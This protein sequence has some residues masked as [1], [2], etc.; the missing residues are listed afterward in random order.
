MKKYVAIVTEEICASCGGS[1]LVED[2]NGM[3]LLCLPC[4]G[5]GIVKKEKKIEDVQQLI[6]EIWGTTQEQPLLK[7]RTAKAN[8]NSERV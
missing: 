4:H 3:E 5:V 8:E 6:N 7:L 2:G 1:G